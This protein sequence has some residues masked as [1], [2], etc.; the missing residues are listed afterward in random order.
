MPSG[1]ITCAARKTAWEALRH[2]E[3]RPEIEVLL[4][5]WMM[6]GLDGLEVCRRARQLERGHYTYIVMITSR[7]GKKDF[8]AG[9]LAGADDFMTKPLDTDEL[10]ARMYS[11]ERVIRLKTEAQLQ[12]AIASNSGADEMKSAFISLTSHEMRSP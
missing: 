8:M 4:L 10:R 5:D 12:A 11:A 1:G 7:S 2:F 3:S 9:M 6:P